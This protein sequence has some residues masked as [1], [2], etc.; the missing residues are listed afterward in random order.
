[1]AV[2]SQHFF[3]TPKANNICVTG[4]ALTLMGVT[5]IAQAATFEVTTSH[6]FVDLNL[7]D[8]SCSG[9]PANPG[10]SL[11]AAIQ[12]ANSSAGLDVV[13][14]PSGVYALT[15]S[16][17]N[18]D[19]A[20]TGDLD[21]R[22]TLMIQ[23][24]GST[25]PI[26]DG[27]YRDRVFDIHSSPTA[28]TKLIIQNL[29]IQNGIASF[30]MPPNGGGIL[31]REHSLLRASRCLLQ[32]NGAQFGGAISAREGSYVELSQCHLAGNWIYGVEGFDITGGGTALHSH[33]SSVVINQSSF[34]H[35]GSLFSG[36]VIYTDFGHLSI[37]NSTI[38]NNAG[39][40]VYPESSNVSLRN[41]TIANQTGYGF[42]AYAPTPMVVVT[43]KNSIITN[44]GMADCDFSAAAQGDLLGPNLDSDGS[45]ALDAAS[46]GL[47]ML[48]PMLD[49]LNYTSYGVAYRLPSLTSPAIDSASLLPL[50]SEWAACTWVDQLQQ[51]R[52]RDGDGD[53]DARCDLGAIER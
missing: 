47:S 22:D 33:R 8:G 14:V 16:G 44:S 7:A 31:V 39:T 11:R 30:D 40:G 15:L 38:S 1:M 52:N 32:S 49:S 6:D 48:D 5:A 20:Q 3:Q 51:T 42:R 34:V 50:D 23:G 9:E 46:G 45:C 19:D 4:L 26:I 41:T 43:M 28:T 21:V 18:E 24:Q 29:T 25:Q 10:C 13:I 53:G 36:S 17:Y 27:E 37:E 2:S 35:N 12:N